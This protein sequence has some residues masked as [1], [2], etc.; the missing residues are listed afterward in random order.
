MLLNAIIM[1]MAMLAAIL[2]IGGGLMVLVRQQ[3]V[4]DDAGNVSQIE[5][6]FFGKLTTNYPSLVAIIAGVALAYAVQSRIQVEVVASTL[7]LTARVSVEGLPE[8]SP[9]FVNAVPQK[10]LR[11]A[12][13]LQDPDGAMQEMVLEVDEPGP[14]NVIAYTV[15]GLTATGQPIFAVTQG[16]AIRSDGPDRFEFQGRLVRDQRAEAPQ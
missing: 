8:N 13:V 3:V 15:S 2:A 10:Y 9:I 4:V 12:T 6:P 1:S 7:P 5:I 14:Y 16:P 11:T